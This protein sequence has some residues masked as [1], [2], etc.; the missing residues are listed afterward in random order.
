MSHLRRVLS[1]LFILLLVSAC[2]TVTPEPAAAPTETPTLTP[3]V[4]ATPLPQ[5][6]PLPRAIDLTR[7][8]DPTQQAYMRIIHAAPNAPTFNVYV[9]RLAVATNLSYTQSTEPSGIVA[10]EYTLR[11]IP[12]GTR[13]DESSAIFET[14]FSPKGGESLILM[15]TGTP[16]AL[17]MSSF[18]E[19]TETLGKNQ[20]RITF[21]QAVQGSGSITMQQNNVDLT[22]PLAFG[23]AALPVT[24][25]SGSINLDF[26]NESGILYSYP[27]T[28]QERV[29]YTLVLVGQPDNLA[30]IKGE[31]RAPGN[32]SIRAVNAVTSLMSLDVTLDEILLAN[33]LDYSRASERRAVP[34]HIY[35]V[36]VYPAGADRSSTQPL[37]SRQLVANNDDVVT[38]IIVGS[39]DDLRVVDY[40]ENLSPTSPSQTR[41]AFMNILS[42]F[43][44]VRV[45]TQAGPM[46]TVGDLG[47]GQPPQIATLETAGIYTF[48]WNKVEAGTAGEQVESVQNVIFE[49]GRTY[50]YM[51]TGVLD[52]PPLILSER[53]GI[54]EELAG[55][56]LGETPTAT[57]EIPTRVRFVNAV[58]GGLPMTLRLNDSPLV[59]ALAYSNGSNLNIVSSGDYTIEA[60]VAESGEI[61]ATAEVSFDTASDYSIFAYGFGTQNIQLMVVSDAGVVVGGNSPHFR[62]V[63]TTGS[64]D[65]HFGLAYSS[66]TA[67]NTNPSRLSESPAGELFRRSIPFGVTTIIGMNAR[68]ATVS[69]VLLAPL[70]TYDVHVLDVVTNEIAATI[71]QVNLQ[72][73]ILYDVVAFQYPESRRVE[74]FVLPYPVD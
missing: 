61:L 70:G 18:T 40:R 66:S 30:V 64:G 25:A 42:G 67:A 55:L 44:S 27:I 26:R 29:S 19:S 38:L 59:S 48:F 31:I 60:Q 12:S 33:N 2:D 53:V 72:P 58:S 28:L 65:A 45:E 57:P 37:A 21:I 5:P 32:A 50:L 1:I 39:S 43:P 62:I 41:V 73:G 68:Q 54:N 23:G 24:L 35:A 13:L 6:T 10:G 34:A 51:V 9:E 56:A 14:A 36:N 52:S 46:E 69:N 17:T 71:R 74:G 11:V 15:F 47:F 22:P 16:D 4:T 7:A 63:N 3:T 49:P 20:S 8:T